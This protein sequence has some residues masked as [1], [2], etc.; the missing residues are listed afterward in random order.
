MALISFSDVSR[1]YGR[2]DVLSGVTLAINPGERVG[3]VGRNG[4]GKTTLMK[5]LFGLYSPDAG[6]IAINGRP[7][8]ATS[9]NTAYELGLG[10]VHQHFLLI[11]N[12]TVQ[13]QIRLGCQPGP[14]MGL[15]PS[16]IDT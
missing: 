9:P 1:F 4:A 10:L 14:G 15:D 16:L 5:V 13:E 7:V 12:P 11:A 3:L 6:T 8:A 2:Q